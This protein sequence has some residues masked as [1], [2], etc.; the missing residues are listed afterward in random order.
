MDNNHCENLI[1]PWA[2]ARKAWLSAGSEPAGQRAAMA[3]SLV[4]PAKIN[5]HDP[6]AYLDDVL[7]RLTTHLNSRASTNCFHTTCGA[8]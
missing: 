2:L 5:G 6:H 1:R 4:Q 7:T 8:D 3:M